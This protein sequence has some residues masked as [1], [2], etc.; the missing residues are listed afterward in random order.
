MSNACLAVKVLQSLRAKEV[1]SRKCH[2][3]NAAK[4]GACFVLSA[5]YQQQL[6][7]SKQHPD[8][9][10]VDLLI[11]HWWQLTLIPHCV[12]HDQPAHELRSMSDIL[13]LSAIYSSVKHRTHT[14]KPTL[15]ID[16]GSRLRRT[17]DPQ[18]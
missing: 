12:T 11:A 4:L 5:A 16:V 14:R 9:S 15:E 2:Q 18:T 7:R 17:A 1:L 10:A 3:E 13:C 8:F 6:C